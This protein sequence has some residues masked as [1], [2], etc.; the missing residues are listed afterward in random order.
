[1]KSNKPLPFEVPMLHVYTQHKGYLIQQRTDIK[2]NR[3]IIYKN[4]E[5]VKCIVGD[6]LA[7][8]TENSIDKAKSWI[9]GVEA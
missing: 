8:G 9:D 3:A 2:S 4:N 6:I 7:D 1:M 5:L